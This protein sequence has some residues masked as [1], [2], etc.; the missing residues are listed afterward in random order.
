MLS[1]FCVPGAL[2][3]IKVSNS[4]PTISSPIKLSEVPE[5]LTKPVSDASLRRGNAS[6]S[7]A[8]G[9][10]YKKQMYSVP[11]DGYNH[12]PNI[13]VFFVKHACNLWSL[14]ALEDNYKHFNTFLN[15]EIL[16]N[17]AS[18]EHSVGYHAVCLILHLRFSKPV[19]ELGHQDL[20]H[21]SPL[22]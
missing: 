17:K 22:S 19:N 10:L 3:G 11:L 18:A 4:V 9:L 5:V 21:A 12:D 2:Q 6:T 8:V 15:T 13:F 7:E 1:A 20:H 16:L 14:C